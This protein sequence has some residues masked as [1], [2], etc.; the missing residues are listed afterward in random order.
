MTMKTDELLKRLE[1]D[2]EWAEA[3][4]EWELPLCLADDL[5][6]CITL[7]KKKTAAGRNTLD[8]IAEWCEAYDQGKL[9][10]SPC[11]VGDTVYYKT[12]EKGEYVGI[13]P[14]RVDHIRTFAVTTD[15]NG[16]DTPVWITEF[17]K[18][19]FLT[20][21]KAEAALEREGE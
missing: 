2:L 10:V 19:V 12:Y 8:M 21:E 3:A 20:R 5:R 15:K 14:H 7:L 13:K 17:G 9:I 6:E 11:A 4:G 16:L 18:S 1:V